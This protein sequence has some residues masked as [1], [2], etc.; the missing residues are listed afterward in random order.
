MSTSATTETPLLPEPRKAYITVIH[1]NSK[2]ARKQG[3]WGWSIN[4]MGKKEWR[5]HDS[6]QV[7][8]DPEGRPLPHKEII[9]HTSKYMPHVGKKHAAK[10][11]KRKLQAA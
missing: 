10:L 5:N 1:T 6:L 4:K 2:R 11:A 9:R 3:L 7:L 8:R